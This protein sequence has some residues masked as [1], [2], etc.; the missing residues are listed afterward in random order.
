ME[1]AIRFESYVELLRHLREPLVIA[2]RSGRILAANAAAAEALGTSIAALENAPLSAHSPDPAAL[3]AHLGVRSFP[4]RARD[5]RSFSFEASPL[6]SDMLVLR[7][8][9]GPVAAPRAHA[10]FEA[11]YRLHGITAC[12]SDRQR[13]SELCHALLTE[14]MGSVGA[15]TGGVFLIDEAGEN[16]ELEGSIGFDVESADRFGLVS[17]R[18]TRSPRLGEAGRSHPARH[19]RR[20]RRPLP[21]LRQDTPDQRAF[22]RGLRPAR[23]GGASHRHSRARVSV[24]MGLR[25]R[26]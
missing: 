13:V 8:A 16:L 14:G 21:R 24:A 9:E 1:G 25:G 23:G 2:S 19:H 3:D 4:L 15:I 10:F 6:A 11:I 26:R 18:P 22:R 7:L 17:Q 20:L 12:V 5:G